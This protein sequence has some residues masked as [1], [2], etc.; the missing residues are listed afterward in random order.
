MPR[1]AYKFRFYPDAEQRELLARTFGCVRFVYN[2]ILR[3][4]TDAYDNDGKSVGYAAANAQ[5]SQMKRDDSL[6]WLRE[7]SSVPLQQ[8][9]RHQQ[10][11]FR[12]FFE[13]RARYPR[14]KSKHARQSAEFTR[15]A[16]SYR[17][18]KLRIAKCSTPLDV[19]WSRALPSAP[20]TL[21][22][23]RDAAGRYFVSMLC[24][25]EP[26]PHPVTARTVGIDMGLTHL[27]ILSTGEKVA[28]ARCT[29]KYAAKLA[30]AQRKLARCQ[31]GSAN[32]KKAKRRVARLHA[33]I[34]D[35][36]LD[37]LHKL[38]RRLVD[39]NQVVCVETLNVRGMVRNRALAKSISDV[40]WGEL[41]RQLRYKAE[42]AGRT[43]VEV[44][45]FYP[46]SKRCHGCGH[47]VEQLP[48]DVRVWTCGECGVEHDR[49][50]NAAKNI[51]AAGLAVLASGGSG[52]PVSACAVMGGAR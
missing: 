19:R 45:R 33:K 46:S 11:A 24:E 23:S 7:V 42:W 32:R 38:S 30:R 41:V 1:R 50:L 52:R 34:A 31:K 10:R 16:F 2:A 49:D 17:N 3:Y 36:R 14:F 44:D 37:R 43:L 12:N 4:R 39:E 28:N 21:T 18:G 13:G 6:P 15:S 9:L 5:L 27:A 25:F 22:V 51:R 26:T 20:S 35:G 47:I 29:A 40:A 8:C 48:L